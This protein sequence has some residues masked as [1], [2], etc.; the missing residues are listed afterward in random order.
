V[1]PTTDL[2]ETK[3]SI[4]DKGHEVIN[5]WKIKQRNT[6]KPLSMFFVDLKPQDNNKDIYSI[7][8]LL[9]ICARFE[10]PP[11]RREIPQCM[12]CQKYG[13]TSYGPSGCTP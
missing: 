11:A 5:I 10:A 9:N 6:N 3:R 1:Y 2:A 4:M 7:K 13:H 12:K 8:L